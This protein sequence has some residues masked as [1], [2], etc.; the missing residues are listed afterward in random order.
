MKLIN[1]IILAMEEQAEAKNVLRRQ[2]RTCRKALSPE[3]RKRASEIICAKLLSDGSILAA[4]DP[5]EGGGAVAVYLASP[6]ELDL[7]DFI[8]EMLGYGVKV[9]APRWN[10]ETYALARIKGLDEA[11]LRRGPMNILEPAETETVEPSEIAAWIVPGLAFTQ[12]GKRL[13]YGGGWYDRLLAAANGTLKIG[14]AH[15]FQIVDD[16]P[17]EPHDI[18]LDRVVTP[19]RSIYCATSPVWHR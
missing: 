3:A 19:E 1:D 9:V 5:L 12:D 8:R 14:V 4:I 11:N 10:G 15:E 7:S 17:H 6:D 18:L 13:G 2:M 16:L